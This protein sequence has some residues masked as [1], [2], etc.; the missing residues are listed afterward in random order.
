MFLQLFL[1][2]PVAEAAYGQYGLSDRC[3]TVSA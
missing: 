3:W 2:T 1:L